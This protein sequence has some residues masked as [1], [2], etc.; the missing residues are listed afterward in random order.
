MKEKALSTLLEW[1][2]DLVNVSFDDIT[3][4]MSN[5]IRLF[6]FST[7]IIHK[8]AIIERVRYNE[9]GKP[10]FTK[11][12]DISYI[13]D[14]DTIKQCLINFGRCNKPFTP[15]FYGS[16]ESFEI[17]QPRATALSEARAF[18]TNIENE[19]Y[20]GDTFTVGRWITNRDFVCAEIIFAQKAILENSYVSRSYRDRL[21]ELVVYPDKTFNLNLTKF[22]SEEF[23]KMIQRGDEFNYKISAA[24][25][26][27]VFYVSGVAGIIFPSVATDCRGLNI[28]L[29][30]S[31]VDNFLEFKGAYTVTT[32]GKGKYF[33]VNPFQDV[34]SWDKGNVNFKYQ[35]SKH[36]ISSEE[37]RKRVD[38]FRE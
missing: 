32:H 14:P 30:P 37:I 16:I 13:R 27:L 11:E 33:L 25:S 7:A 3:D 28:A 24:V 1:Q 19:S 26:E 34:I 38:K 10:F 8:G 29:K 35:D 15:C 22:Y 17:P 36:R 4:L 18:Y 2:K 23:A 21:K 20:E 31:A 12:A 6:P 5:Q 9:P